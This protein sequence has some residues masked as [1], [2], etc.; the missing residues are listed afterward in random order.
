MEKKEPV[1]CLQ[2]VLLFLIVLIVVSITGGTYFVSQQHYELRDLRD[3]L[4]SQKLTVKANERKIVQLRQKFLELVQEARI[5][6]FPVTRNYLLLDM[7][8]CLILLHIEQ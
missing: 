1:F 2:A 6:L 8:L 5:L 3:D 4:A 7:I